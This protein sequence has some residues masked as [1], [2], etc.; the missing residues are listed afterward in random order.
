MINVSPV[1][2]RKS[3]AAFWG[4][5][6]ALLANAV[7]GVING[8]EKSLEFQGVGYRALVNGDVLE[9]SLGF[10]HPVEYKA[11]FYNKHIIYKAVKTYGGIA[12]CS[13]RT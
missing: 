10:S 12:L 3:L 2:E 1:T 9:L 8:F 7:I 6:R 11:H 4:L 13:Y 5:T